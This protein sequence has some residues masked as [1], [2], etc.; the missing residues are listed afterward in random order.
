MTF[1]EG[2]GGALSKT[3]AAT[4]ARV[5][6]TLNWSAR[7]RAVTAP[8]SALSANVTL[9]KANF[10]GSDFFFIINRDA[11]PSAFTR[12]YTSANEAQTGKWRLVVTFYAQANGT[13]SVVGIATAVVT[14]AG[15]GSGIGTVSTQNTVTACSINTTPPPVIQAT[16]EG[17]LTVTA[18]D[19][20]KNIVAVTPGSIFYTVTSGASNLAVDP[21]TGKLHG[22]APGAASVTASVDGVTSAPVTVT[23][24]PTIA[25]NI[26][27]TTVTVLQSG[28]QQFMS[29]VTGTSN[30]AVQWSVEQSTGGTITPTGFYTAPASA[31]MFTVVATSAAD[32]TKHAT[33]QV[34]VPAVQASSIFVADNIRD[35]ITRTVDMAGDAAQVYGSTSGA[36]SLP[37][38]SSVALDASGRI[39]ITESTSNGSDGN[40]IVRIDS[41][42]GGER[43]EFGASH[44]SG[45]GQFEGPTCVAI[46]PID[47]RVY[48]ADKGNNRIVS[49]DPTFDN[50]TGWQSISGPPAGVSGPGFSNPTGVYVDSQG[51][52]W[53]ADSGNNRIVR[54]DDITGTNWVAYGKLGDLNSTGFHNPTGVCAIGGFVY[55]ADQENSRVCR[56]A[57]DATLSGAGFT[58]YTGSGSLLLAGP[59]GVW[60]T[61][62]GYIY[63]ADTGNQR[64]ERIRDIQGDN[65]SVYGTNGAQLP[66]EFKSPVFVLA[67]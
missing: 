11:S 21:T 28:T 42:T 38:A 45:V 3:A 36:A 2:C 15:D 44:G 7:S 35:D 6:I 10:D 52:I 4:S 53:V 40:H 32:P 59:S 67:R 22:I 48:V 61:S 49:F 63:I 56:M 46:G 31:G 1:C 58:W 34:T 50:I 9:K 37:G 55:V 43:L 66:G 64:I 29:T 54:M 51:K 23:V 60:S 47:G 26:S 30:A 25:I 62:D 39:Y 5:K 65:A 20:A 16:Q 14:I 33:A 27:P 12:L 19:A 24:V 18:Y 8:S 41:I 57:D 17:D 13:G